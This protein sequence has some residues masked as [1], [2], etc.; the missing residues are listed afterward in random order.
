MDGLDN[1]NFAG[2]WLLDDSG[3][4]DFARLGFLVGSERG[5]KYPKMIH[6]IHYIRSNFRIIR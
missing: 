2:S 4:N 5:S 3:K 6:S 1:C